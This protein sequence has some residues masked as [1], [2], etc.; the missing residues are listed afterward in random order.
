MKKNFKSFLGL[1][2]FFSAL[3]SSSM[4]ENGGKNIMRN[5]RSGVL[6]VFC[7][8]GLLGFQTPVLAAS[9][10]QLVAKGNALFSAGKY[11]EALEVYEKAE[12]NAPE[13]PYLYF[14]KGT[15]LYKKGD[16]AAA[17]EAFQQAALKSK[18]MAL[19][20]K[21]KFNLGLCAVR[22]AERQQDSDLNKALDAYGKSIQYFREALEL[23]PNFQEAAENI[24][25]VRLIMK[26][27]LDEI[28]KREEEAKKQQEQMQNA[29]E[30]LKALIKQQ[31]ALIERNSTLSQKA[32][33]NGPSE[34][35]SSKM[36][37]LAKEQ[38][39][40]QHDT[41]QLAE[42]L[43]NQK[44]NAQGAQTEAV[45][46]LDD[47]IKEQGLAVQQLEQNHSQTAGEH[48]Q[49][50]LE[51]LIKAQESFKQQQQQGQQQ[52]QQS[53]Q[54]QQQQQQQAQTGQQENTPPDQEKGQAGSEQG[55]Q[56]EKQQQASVVQLPDDAESILDEEKENNMRRTYGNTSGG[57]SEVDKDW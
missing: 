2:L 48:Q 24:E 16:Y 23:D 27:M 5:A 36:Q 57:Y 35:M 17:N 52:Q 7:I 14:N 47:S 18:D 21:S 40:L 53:Q 10:H 32:R 20:S 33:Q 13:S 45:T 42:T 1:H 15:A 39:A 54:G 51:S 56:Q 19:E 12:V 3:S 37:N 38:G 8:A 6:W 26:S 11:D 22:E 28:K 49:N 43:A 29:A 50:S 30:K 4:N 9:T 55:Q 34:D 31:Q 44:Q 46:H 25:L 41:Q